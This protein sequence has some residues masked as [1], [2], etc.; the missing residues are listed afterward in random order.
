MAT[1]LPL[2]SEGILLS[3]TDKYDSQIIEE[4]EIDSPEFRQFLI[5][6]QQ[7]LNDHAN[8]MNRKDYAAYDLAESINGQT[9]FQGNDDGAST[10]VNFRQVYRKV[11]NIGA[12]DNAAGTTVYPHGIDVTD[13]YAFTRIYG[14]ANRP[15]PF[16]A[17]PLPYA[18]AT[19]ADVIELNVD[20]TNINITIGKDLSAFTKTTVVLEYVKI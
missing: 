4:L 12:L 9:W 10:N 1:N 6:I 18:S 19:A 20:A 3:T 17:L 16:L 8:Y 14:V 13:T 2:N 11:I 15:T 7:A 5:W